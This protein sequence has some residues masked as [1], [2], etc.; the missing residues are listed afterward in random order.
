MNIRLNSAKVE[1]QMFIKFLHLLFLVKVISSVGSNL[2][3]YAI[4]ENPARD[5]TYSTYQGNRYL[6]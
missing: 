5:S 3:E 6:P 2:Y 1:V 4:I